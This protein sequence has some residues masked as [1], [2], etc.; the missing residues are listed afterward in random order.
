[1]GKRHFVGAE[2][3]RTICGRSKLRPYREPPEN[4]KP[5]PSTL[6]NPFGKLD[7]LLKPP[8]ENG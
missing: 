2:L 4:D 1:M 3:A 8:P 6:F 7:G 5:A